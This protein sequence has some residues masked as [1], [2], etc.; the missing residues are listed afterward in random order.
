MAEGHCRMNIL[1]YS[2]LFFPSIGGLETVSDT[3]ANGLIANSIPCKVITTSKYSGNEEFIFEV[4]RKPNLRKQLE[5]IRWADVVIYNGISLA[6][7]PFVLVFRKPI[8][9]IHVGYQASCI[10][11]LGWVDGEKAPLSPWASF[12]FHIKKKG[13]RSAIIG[14]MKLQ[15]K[16]I[17]AYHLV[18]K[19]VAI[20]QWMNETQPLPRQWV[21]HNPFPLGSFIQNQNNFQSKLYDFVYLG[22]LVSE[23]GVPILLEAFGA[24]VNQWDRNLKLLI[25]GDGNWKARLEEQSRQLGISENVHFAGKIWGKELIDIV[26]KAKIG[27]VPSVWFEPMGGVALELI[28]SGLPVIVSEEGGLKECVGRAGLTFPNGDIQTLAE[29]MKLLLTDKALYNDLKYNA[30]NQLNTFGPASKI[31]AYIELL[32]E[33]YI[34]NNHHNHI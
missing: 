34:K 27:I 3:L 28:A 4:Y 18:A 26:P 29:K 17:V 16:R 25:I 21:I 19:N 8:V 2:H 24:L 20:T 5:L 33:V 9:W 1:L 13:W 6:M 14:W 30:E 7:I 11:G 22:R 12:L 15:L 31:R 23:K 32:N 10:D